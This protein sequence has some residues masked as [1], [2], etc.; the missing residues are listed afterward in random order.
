[1][2]IYVDGLISWT[3]QVPVQAQSVTASVTTSQSIV[4]NT[5][6]LIVSN[7]SS[8]TH[9]LPSPVGHKKNGR[10][11]F[12]NLHAT[13]LTINTVSGLINGVATDTIAQGVTKWYTTFDNINWYSIT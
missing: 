1:M 4:A 3:D 9:S 2:S 13:A 6:G 11:G 10:V 5:A 8:L 7:G 12:K